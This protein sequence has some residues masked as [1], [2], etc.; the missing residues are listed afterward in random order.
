VFH[1][2]SSFLKLPNDSKQYLKGGHEYAFL[3]RAQPISTYVIVN[4]SLIQTFCDRPCHRLRS[5]L[6]GSLWPNHVQMFWMSF[7]VA[8]IFAYEKCTFVRRYYYQSSQ[9]W[10]YEEFEDRIRT[11][12]DRSCDQH[13]LIFKFNL[14]SFETS[15]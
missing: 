7:S 2:S 11:A 13:L 12:S 8:W 15:T 14:A 9:I 4:Q 1:C 3:I 10:N 5:I 6:G